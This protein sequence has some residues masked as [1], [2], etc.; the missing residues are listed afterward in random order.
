MRSLLVPFPS[1]AASTPPQL[2]CGAGPGHLLD[3][4]HR[5]VQHSGALL[6][7]LQARDRVVRLL[8]L[9][10]RVRGTAEK[11]N[12]LFETPQTP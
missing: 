6:C 4:L 11:Y 9:G 1:P 8:H 7:V 10:T 5:L 2:S 12:R 3:V